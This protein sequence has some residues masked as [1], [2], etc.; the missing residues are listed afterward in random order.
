MPLA[1]VYFDRSGRLYTT[2][3]PYLAMSTEPQ[4]DTP[5]TETINLGTG[6]EPLNIDVVHVGIFKDGEQVA[7]G[8]VNL[9]GYAGADLD[10]SQ[11]GKHLGRVDLTAMTAEAPTSIPPGTTLILDQPMKYVYTPH[12]H[13]P[14]GRVDRL[15]EIMG[16]LFELMIEGEAKQEKATDHASLGMFAVL[17]RV[18]EEK[19]YP[20]R[21]K[22][23]FTEYQTYLAEVKASDVYR[24]YVPLA[25]GPVRF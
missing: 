1:L 7:G 11:L 3:S 8:E 19:S 16:K 5:A 9:T 2:Q 18:K 13:S 20:E 4:N 24:R 10:I 12:P 21:L 25:A 15:E 6:N 14:E 23:L 22:E 17:P